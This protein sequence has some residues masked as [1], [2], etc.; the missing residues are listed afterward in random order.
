VEAALAKTPLYEWHVERQ[1]RVVDFA[2][3][4][5]P[6]QYHSIVEEHRAT[7]TAAGLFDISHMGRLRF[8]GPDAEAFLDRLLTRR[9]TGLAPNLVR[10][11]LVTNEAG[12]ILDD[13]LV[14]HMLDA[15]GK[16]F[17]MLVVNASNRGKIVSWIEIQRRDGEEL[18]LQDL[19]RDTAMIAVQGPNALATVEE[20]LGLS[21][22]RMKY[23]TAAVSEIAGQAGIV[24]RTGYTGEDG[25]ELIVPGSAAISI[26]NQISAAG[27]FRGLQ[28]VG[29]GARD[30]LRLEA[31]M[32]LYGHELSEEINP[33]TAG[34]GFAVQ[35]K[36]REFVGSTELAKQKMSDQRTR[37]VGLQLEGK[38]VPREN[39]PVI[40]QDEDV[41]TVTSGTFS[42]TL[43]RP[44]AMAYLRRDVSAV[45]TEVA[46]DIRGRHEPA[47]VVEFPFYRRPV[48]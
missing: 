43:E 30:T 39:Y 6:V 21:I 11:S 42:P 15:D 20:A 4:A 7:R 47:R 33:Y 37:R 41:G 14:Y 3:W 19:T 46:V 23:Y 28:A 17:Y 22:E 44:I 1:A 24:S 16:S 27:A 18:G 13:V 26:V 9:V 31:G 2:G 40:V 34:L 48:T 12:G 5:M 8:D 32:P 10:Y 25:C 35:L 29:L 45:G 38:R 36:D